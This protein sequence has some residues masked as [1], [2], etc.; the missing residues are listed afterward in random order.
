MSAHCL[1]KPYETWSIPTI[2]YDIYSTTVLYDIYFVSWCMGGS[3]G[4][5]Y[6]TTQWL[7]VIP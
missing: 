1:R 5:L 2:Q 3:K 4:L 6:N 7:V